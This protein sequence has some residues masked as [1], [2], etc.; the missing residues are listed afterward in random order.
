QQE[1]AETKLDKVLSYYDG[2][3]DKLNTIAERYG[4][5]NSLNEALGSDT[6]SS[7]IS[8]LNNQKNYLNQAL[9]QLQTQKSKY[10]SEY[11]ANKKYFTTEQHQSALKQIEEI[12]NTIYETK[13]SIAE[14]TNE[15]R[16][17]ELEKI[18]H[19]TERFQQA[20]D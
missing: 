11:N 9:S 13:T 14:L 19:A 4:A 20:A 10:Q 16:S 15:I 12:N 7:R 17:L 1:L 8:N 3:I 2:Y 6:S 18:E 5:I